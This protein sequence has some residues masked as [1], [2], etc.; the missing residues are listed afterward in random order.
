MMSYVFSAVEKEKII[1]A[2]SMCEGMRFESRI[3]LYQAVAIKGLNC[4][5]FYQALS[6]MIGEKLSGSVVFDENIKKILKSAKLWLD[7]AIDANGGNGAYSALIRAYTMRQGQ[8][9]LNKVFSDELMQESSNQVAVN[10][11]NAL[12]YGSLKDNLAPWTV[13]SIDQIASIDASAIGRVLFPKEVGDEDT[14]S[15]RNSGWSGTIGFSLLGGEYPFETWRLISAGDPGSEIKGRHELAEVNRVDDFKNILFAIDSY[16]VALVAVAKNFGGN[17]LESMFSVLPEQ[18]N[19][20]GSSGSYSPFIQHV[21]KGTPISSTVDMILRYGVN[22]FFD[23]FKLTYDGVASFTPATDETFTANAYAFFSSL[24]SSQSQSTVAKTIVEYGS[25]SEWKEL[26]TQETLV[27]KALRNSLKHLSEIVIERDDDFL[28]RGLELHDPKSGDGVITEQWIVD[29]ADMLGRL[30]SRAAVSFGENTSQ[31]YSYSDLASGKQVPMKTGVSNPLVMFGDDGG[32]SFGGGTSIDHLY[33]GSGDDGINGSEG[34]DYVEGGQGNDSLSGGDGNDALRGMAGDDVLVGGKGNNILIGGAGN[35]EYEFTSGDGI[36]QIYD[37]NADGQILINGLPIPLPKRIGPLSNTWLTEDGVITLT[38]IEEPTEKTLNIKYGQNDLIVIKPYTPGMLG[39][40]LPDYKGQ[41]IPSPD[42]TV[43]GDLKAKDT[44]PDVP[45]DQFSYD[46]LGNVVVMPGVKERNRTDILHGSSNNDLLIG[47]GGSDRL[48]GRAGNDRLF[49]DKKTT[50]EKA[51]AGGAVRGR[52]SRGDWLDGGVGDDLLIGTPSRDVLLGG[53][54]LDTLI[55]G[56]GDDNISGDDTTAYLTE[57]WDF[58]IVNVPLGHGVVSNRGVL[59]HASSSNAMEGGNDILY[60]QGGRDFMAGGWGDDLLDGGTG[61]DVMSGDQGNDTLRGGSDDDLLLGDNLDWVGGLQSRNHGNDFLDGGDGNDELA[62]NGGS[63]VLYGGIGNDDLK[64]DDPVIQGIEGDAANY[65]GNDFLD[66]GA[67]DDTLQG[68]GA[69]DSLYGGA[70]NDVLSGDYADH[71]ARYQGDDFLDGG[72]GDDT[73]RGMGGSDTLIGGPGA[74]ALDGDEHSL[75]AGITNDDYIRGGAGNDT[76]WGG[77]GADT[78][79]GGADDDFLLGDYELRPETEHG[80]DYLDGGA[81]NDTLIGGGGDDTLIGGTGGDYL[82]GGP[83]NNIFEGGSGKDYLDGSD[84]DDT[85][86]FSI[87]DGIDV[88]ADTGGNNI[89]KFGPG[90]AASNLKVGV[91]VVDIG[92]VLRLTN[93]LGDAVRIRDF[94]KWQNSS[95]GFSDGVVLSFQEVMAIAQGSVDI[96]PLAEPSPGSGADDGGTGAVDNNTVTEQSGE[97]DN[98]SGAAHTNSTAGDTPRVKTDADKLWSEEFMN[99]LKKRRSAF[100]LAS[101]FLLNA[102]GVWSKNHIANDEYSY[103][104]KT[105]LIVE[106]FQAGSLSETPERMSLVSGKSVISERTSSLTSRTESRPAVV[107]GLKYTQ[108]QEPHYYPSGSNYSGFALSAGEVVVEHKSATGVIQGWYVYPAGSFESSELSY[109]K[110]SWDVSTE[111][112]K[113]QIVQGDDAG[114]RVNLEVGNVFHGGAG[115]D[116]VVT[117]KSPDVIYGEYED[118]ASGAFLSGGAGN[119]TLVGSEGADYLVSGAGHDRL[120]GENGPD[121]YIIAPHAGATTIVA[122]MLSPVFLRPEV[123]AAG[124]YSEFGAEDVDTVRLPDGVTLEQLQLNWGAVLVEAVNIELVPM[125]KRG[126][127]RN[128]PRGQMLYSTLD[129]AWSEY[130]QI[131]IVLPNS[132]DLKGSG[133]ELIKFSD[134]SNIRL[135]QLIA[136]SELGPAPDT[137]HNGISID[138]AVEALSFRTGKKLPLVG[139]RGNDTLSGSGEIRGMQGDDTISGGMG[140]DT[141]WGGG[142]NDTLAGGAGNDI[143]KYDGLGR[144]L[145]INALGGFDGIDFTDFDA[146][147]HQLKF[148]RDN[149]DLVVVVN[150]GASPKIRVANH[151][152]GGEAAISFIRVQSVDRTP[153][154]YTANQLLELLHPLPPLRDMEG[155]FLRDDEGVSEALKEISEFYGIQV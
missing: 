44:D 85:Y 104:E 75:Q 19:I 95:F 26:A 93:G 42:L 72:V 71:P 31:A 144:D 129:V 86:H 10:F 30:I 27:G 32:R 18:I 36:D 137:Y 84:G 134:G 4:A 119:D 116:L 133:I 124:W 11:M 13:P 58:K 64:G 68:G 78:L 118:R 102:Q 48:F 16:W 88:I 60:G 106:S 105:N 77:L 131:R 91:V 56:A 74:D 90:F 94:E 128:S 22:T 49:G 98:S 111:T 100:M 45:G 61:N 79:Y 5:P 121:T 59:S 1:D 103:N 80:A 63:D 62:G 142:G 92:P 57:N 152:L 153:Q 132:S 149:N 73:L 150:Y 7:V 130:Q 50:I 69:D 17:T 148:H 145:I 81:G 136:D 54:G 28:G 97:K 65:F 83:G 155:I 3:E 46:E 138:N 122:D 82:R 139:G 123:G 109:K 154:D 112:I 117:Y 24:S 40:Q 38:L 53:N 21:V 115:D 34:N 108:K 101:G 47:L 29:R 140:D 25:V 114:G 110:F 20:A 8:L 2:A 23:M 12:M 76:L 67:G 126:T 135:E 51:M 33:G 52:A 127:Y 41:P 39:I 141:L 37:I 151:F 66:G 147:I 125:P 14:A 15:S 9:R 120:Y 96:S 107:G 55:G 6:E 99:N 87:G 35:D 89:I 143:Y 43:M 146:S 70:G 113:H